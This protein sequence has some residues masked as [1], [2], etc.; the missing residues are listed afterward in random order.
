MKTIFTILTLII[1]I[2]VG[3][4]FFFPQYF[5]GAP[6]A[7]EQAATPLVNSGE[8]ATTTER[9]PTSVIGKSVEG[10]DIVAYHFGQGDTELLFVGGIHGGYSWNTALVAYELI[11]HLESNADNIPANVSVTVVPALNPDGLYSV[12]KK[13]GRFKARDIPSGA[14][15]VAGRFNARDVDLNRNFDCD[16]KATGTWQSRAVSGGSAAFSEPESQA[17][18]NYVEVNDPSAVVVYYSSA[19]GVFASNCHADVLPETLELTNEYAE[20]SGYRAYEEFDFYSITG[21]MVN[22]LAGEGI[23]AISVLLTNHTDVEWDKNLAGVEAL[24]AH[25]AEDETETN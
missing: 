8:Q 7:E 18:Q 6:R 10:R 14:D 4:Y 12:V 19:G 3:A 17:I 21:D 11:D 15:T 5:P 16:W 25:Y 1:L 20:A 22:W 9:E 24:L 23:P 2:A 13:E